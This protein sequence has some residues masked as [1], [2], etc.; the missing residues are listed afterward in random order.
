MKNEVV[1]LPYFVI[2]QGFIDAT[3]APSDGPNPFEAVS[4]VSQ[5]FD[6]F[7][8]VNMLAMVEARS[9]FSVFVCHFPDAVHP[10][11]FSVDEYTC[12]VVNSRYTL[13]WT[14]ARWGLEP[15]FVLYPP[16]DMGD[17]P[18]P[19]DRIYPVRGAL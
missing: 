14:R 6:V 2:H 3:R 8:N 1:P 4:G 19:K 13:S 17:D 18:A 7:V 5:Q 12:M 15:A 9:P 11:N 16:I 10:L